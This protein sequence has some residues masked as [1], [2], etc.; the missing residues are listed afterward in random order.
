MRPCERSDRTDLQKIENYASGF[1]KRHGY[2]PT[3]ARVAEALDIPQKEL[4]DLVL[5][6]SVVILTRPLVAE[7]VRLGQYSVEVK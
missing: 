4:Q 2:P 1:V 3:V 6:S 7:K 5:Q